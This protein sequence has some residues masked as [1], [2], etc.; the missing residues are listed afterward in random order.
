MIRF[1]LSVALG[2]AVAV[3]L[4]GACGEEEAAK[5]SGAA[6]GGQTAAAAR[7]NQPPTITRVTLQ[8]SD[9]AAG[10]PV[11]VQVQASDPDGDLLR[12]GFEWRL[13]GRTLPTGADT[14]EL[15]ESRKGDLLEVTVTATDGRVESAPVVAATRMG[16]RAPRLESITV[17]PGSAVAVGTPLV[18]RPTAKDADDDELEFEFVWTVNGD[19]V[20]VEGP[21]FKT[22]R[23]RKGD[24]V[25]VSVVATD[26]S[27]ESN[28]VR[29]IPIQVGASDLKIVSSPK[30]GVEDG[31]FAYQVEVQDGGRRS[32]RYRLAKGPQGMSID[33]LSGEIVW[34]P[35]NDQGGS[36]PVEVVVE[37]PQGAHASQSFEVS[38][39]LDAGTAQP[40]PA[41]KPK[42]TASD[43]GEATGD[44]AAAPAAQ[45]RRGRRGAAP[46]AETPPAAAEE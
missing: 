44:T 40:A 45:G 7:S 21:A 28:A 41:A 3:A 27:D 18:V 42:D 35:A 2:C 6:F 31:L 38:V 46:V 30:G 13:G 26:G 37:D 32:L 10:A 20:D 25:Q 8:P 19:E 11:H 16:N 5:P 34:H 1:K 29:S 15:S 36:H 17:E 43:D 22:D 14:V 9:P 4:L 33:A 23:L 24:V 12:Y 39:T